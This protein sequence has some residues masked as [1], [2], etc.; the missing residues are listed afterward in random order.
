MRIAALWPAVV[1]APVEV[2][3]GDHRPAIE[4]HGPDGI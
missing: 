4:L 2:R 1:L 3:V